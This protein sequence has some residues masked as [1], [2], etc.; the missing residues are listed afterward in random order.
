MK[1]FLTKSFVLVLALCSLFCLVGCGDPYANAETVQAE[2][3]SA[4]LD[5]EGVDFG[6]ELASGFEMKMSA[7][8]KY[9]GVSMKIT[10]TVGILFNAEQTK[11]EQMSAV[12]KVSVA[13]YSESIKAYAKDGWLYGQAPDYD[14]K[15]V[16][17]KIG[18]DGSSAD[19]EGLVDAVEEIDS[20]LQKI[21]EYLTST[22]LE[23]QDVVFKK[24]GD[25]TTGEVSYQITDRTEGKSVLEF[26]FE[27][28][29]LTKMSARTE[30]EGNS[31]RASFERVTEIDMPSDRAL[32]NWVA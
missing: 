16:K 30:S 12:L 11:I 8:T 19:V 4:Y 24:L 18:F 20:M 29:K 17:T 1:K 13:G 14:G 25:E 22:E 27:E 5:Q 21:R 7:T 15:M 10:A 31:V 23:L 2:D 28:N 6:E 9:E 32:E 26:N 3:I